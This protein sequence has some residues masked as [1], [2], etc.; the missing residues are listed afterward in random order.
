LLKKEKM[1]RYRDDLFKV[2]CRPDQRDTFFCVV[3]SKYLKTHICWEQIYAK[4]TQC[5]GARMVRVSRRPGG[6]RFSLRASGF[7]GGR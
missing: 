1:N 4:H 5:A 3:Q 6:G 2:A 7:V